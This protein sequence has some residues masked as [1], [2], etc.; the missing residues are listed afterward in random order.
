[1]YKRAQFNILKKRLD[2]PRRFIQVVTGPRQIGKTTLVHQILEEV[3]IPYHFSSAD[4]TFSDNTTWIEQQWEVARL[5]QKQ[6]NNQSFLL[7]IDEIQKI[8]QWAV[9]KGKYHPHKVLL[10]GSG[11][12]ELVDFLQLHPKDLF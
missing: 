4:D 8:K 12:I 11:G 2:E 3:E 5:K 9:F 6:T 7:V 10:V 1:M